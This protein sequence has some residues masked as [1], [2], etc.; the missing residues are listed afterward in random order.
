MFII[1]CLFQFAIQLHVLATSDEVAG[2]DNRK[3]IL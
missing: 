1:T 3:V 2:G